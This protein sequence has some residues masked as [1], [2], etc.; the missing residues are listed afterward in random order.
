MIFPQS[1]RFPGPGRGESFLPRSR[2]AAEG[3]FAR[4]HARANLIGA[5]VRVA[6]WRWVTALLVDEIPAHPGGR[7]R[8]CVSSLASL[9]DADANGSRRHLHRLSATLRCIRRSPTCRKRSAWA[10]DVCFDGRCSTP[11][12]SLVCSTCSA[13][14][15][16]AGGRPH[17]CHTAGSLCVDRTV[18]D[19]PVP[20][21][22]ALR[23][24]PHVRPDRRD[25]APR[26]CTS[27]E[28]AIGFTS[29]P[30]GREARRAGRAD[31]AHQ[32]VRGAGAA[33]CLAAAGV[34]RGRA[35]PAAPGLEPRR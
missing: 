3:R 8:A 22:V 27:C 2:R 15:R 35:G 30:R 1:P 29:T 7:N 23:R 14:S 5:P 32:A 18:P 13:V 12:T 11:T 28:Q 6:V 20:A 9:R 25:S 24:Q 33:L 10:W 4:E 26:C 34:S 16:C 31:G 17:S 19:V 21:G